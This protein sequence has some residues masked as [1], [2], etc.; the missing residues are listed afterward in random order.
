M[1]GLSVVFIQEYFSVDIRLPVVTSAPLLSVGYCLS[2]CGPSYV[3]CVRW[4]GCVCHLLDC[5]L[6]SVYLL[7]CLAVSLSVVWIQTRRDTVE[8]DIHDYKL[9]GVGVDLHATCY[10]DT[11]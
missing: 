7:C 11:A 6:L 4:P 9:T 10:L 5:P 3:V 2:V 1:C 8:A